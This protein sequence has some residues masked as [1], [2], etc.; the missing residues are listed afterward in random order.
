MQEECLDV[1]SVWHMLQKYG[2]DCG[3]IAIAIAIVG[4]RVSAIEAGMAANAM[5]EKLLKMLVW[6]GAYSCNAA[7][8]VSK[9]HLSGL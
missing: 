4:R 8:Y 7:D 5:D 3:A 2:M 6:L 9:T 1:A